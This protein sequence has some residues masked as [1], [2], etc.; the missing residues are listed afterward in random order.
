MHAQDDAE[1]EIHLAL[2]PFALRATANAAAT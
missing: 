2:L 1:R